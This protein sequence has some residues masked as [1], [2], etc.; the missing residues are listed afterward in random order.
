MCMHSDEHSK[1]KVVWIRPG[2]RVDLVTKISSLLPSLGPL[3]KGR[4][5]QE[6]KL[7]G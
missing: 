2:S 6:A 3:G 7:V 4:R 5:V 1:D